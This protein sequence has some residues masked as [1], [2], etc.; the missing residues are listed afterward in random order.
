MRCENHIANLQLKTWICTLSASIRLSASLNI[1][2]GFLS[3]EK[4]PSNLYSIFI[5]MRSTV[6]T[7]FDA[8]IVHRWRN[9]CITLIENLF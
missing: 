7:K 1:L 6:T 5:A 2:E 3:N 4:E 8:E 9:V